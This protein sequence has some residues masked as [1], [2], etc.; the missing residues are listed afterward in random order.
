M[1]TSETALIIGL[2]IGVTTAQS[3]DEPPPNFKASALLAPALVRGAHHEV[4]ENVRTDA[5]FHE[6]TLTSLFGPFT[7]TGRSQLAVR[8]QEIDALAALQEVS[9]TEVF[10][11]A[12]GQSVV[13]IGQGVAAVAKDPVE[14]AKGLGGGFKR[15]GVNL[16][17]RTQ[18]AVDSASSDRPSDGAAPEKDSAAASAA[19]GVLGVTGAMRRWAAKVGVDPYTT[20]PVLRDA[21]ASIANVDAAGSIA[22]KVAVPV[23]RAVSMTSKVGHLVWDKDPEEVRKINEQRLRELSVSDDVAKSLFTSDWFTLTYQTRFIAALHEVRAVDSADYV[24]T[25]ADARSE[26]EALFF[27]ESAELLQDWHAR[28]PVAAILKDSRTLV[29]AGRRGDATALLPLDYVRWTTKTEQ[30]VREISGRARKELAATR[31]RM[32]LTG[33]A[34][35]RAGRELTGLGWTIVKA[36]TREPA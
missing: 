33:R 8:L 19:K 26:R 15:L 32:V 11:A 21:L 28:E 20:N 6:F 12:A 35:A 2:A 14:T 22:T 7:A 30:T 13:K 10:L 29:A 5:F 31:L 1:R 23:P 17:R 24:H 18:R 3:G 9:K 34:S 4:G 27:V 16:G 36:P 25:A